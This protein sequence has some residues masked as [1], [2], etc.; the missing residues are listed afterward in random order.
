MLIVDRYRHYA[1]IKGRALDEKFIAGFSQS[2][3]LEMV[4]PINEATITSCHGLATPPSSLRNFYA[5][6]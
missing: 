2:E 6:E 4:E 3:A 5:D 1:G